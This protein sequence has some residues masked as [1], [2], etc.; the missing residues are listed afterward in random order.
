MFVHVCIY[1]VSEGAPTRRLPSTSPS[2]AGCPGAGGGRGTG[3]ATTTICC[4]GRCSGSLAPAPVS[5]TGRAEE[6]DR[7]P[8]HGLLSSVPLAAVF[9]PWLEAVAAERAAGR[10]LLSSV[11]GL[12]RRQ[13]RRGGTPPTD[14]LIPFPLPLP[15]PA[16]WQ[17]PRLLL[18]TASLR[19]AKLCS[20]MVLHIPSKTV[21]QTLPPSWA[22]GGPALLWCGQWASCLPR[23]PLPGLAW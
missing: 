15:Y 4:F 23:S 17:L 6:V 2:L 12:A 13:W 3:A 5:C 21:D 22:R 19:K 14:S 1:A 9:G 10:D 20:V 7:A 11:S 16:H 18:P 8:R